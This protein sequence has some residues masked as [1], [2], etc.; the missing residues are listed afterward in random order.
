MSFMD[1]IIGTALMLIIF[2]ALSGLLRTSLV[3]ASLAKSKSI[4]TTAAGSQM[5]YIRSLSYDSVGTLGGIPAG[6]IVQNATTT[7]NG[8]DVGIRTFIQYADDPADGSGAADTNGIITDYKIIKVTAS[9]MV[10]GELRQIVVLS[11]YS[12]QGLETT[13]NGGTLKIVVVNATGAGISG[14]SVRIVNASTS[15]TVDLTT[16]SDVSGTVFLPGAATSTEYQIFVSKTGYSSAQTY[17]RDATNQNPTPGYL[18]VVKDQ[19]TTGTF[20]IDQ[21]SGITFSTYSPIA[22]TTFSDPFSGSTN[23][24]SSSNI[25]V[26][27]GGVE[28]SGGVGNYSLSG[29]L[30]SSNVAPTYL[31]S[32]VSASSTVTAPGGT[33]VVFHVTDGSGTLLPDAVLAGNSAGFSSS[34]DLSGVSVTTYPALALSGDLTTDSVNNTPIIDEWGISY[35]R[36]PVPLPNIAFTLLGAKTVG[37]TGGGAPIYKTSITTSTDSTGTV[38][39]S[40]EW[41]S[42]QFELTSHDVIDVC[43]APVYDLAPAGVLT[44]S[45]TLSTRTTNALVASIISAT[46]S[47]PIIGAT[48]TLTRTG[49]SSSVTTTSCGAAYFGGLTSASDYTLSVSKTGYTSFNATGITVSDHIFYE[50]ALDL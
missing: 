23:I 20:A 30:L 31:F 36:G 25:V 28:L 5:E 26:N 7:I 24:V 34:V 8:L 38:P 47:A 6:V 42:Y 16:F 40:L 3:I 22:T 29:T 4:A 50:A 39:L 10:A 32:W 37:T 18:T 48:V 43:N 49:F 44:S 33:A 1:V 19:T 41:D 17:L 21:L 9:Y 14:A 15:P 46:S 27:A 13:T 35:M 12:P 45:L 2:L 11:N